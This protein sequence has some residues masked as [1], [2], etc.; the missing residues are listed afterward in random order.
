MERLKR[1]KKDPEIPLLS[2]YPKELT[3]MCQRDVCTPM[4]IAA[5]FIIAKIREQQKCPSMD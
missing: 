1:K 5:L 2:I 4:F 3:S